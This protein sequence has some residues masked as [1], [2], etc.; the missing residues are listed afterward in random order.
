MNCAPT[1]Q[2][3]NFHPQEKLEYGDAAL[4]RGVSRGLLTQNDADLIKEYVTE[5]QVC[6]NTRTAAC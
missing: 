3:L 2:N 1:P 4:V 5:L 6:R